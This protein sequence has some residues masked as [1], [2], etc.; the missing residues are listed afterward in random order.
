MDGLAKFF[1]LGRLFRQVLYIIIFI[2]DTYNIE[3]KLSTSFFFL[4]Q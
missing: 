4:R 3:Q 1:S 2:I